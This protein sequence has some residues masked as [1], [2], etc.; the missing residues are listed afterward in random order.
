MIAIKT[1]KW[2]KIAKRR[3]PHAEW[4]TGEGPYALLAH[5]R[6]LTV[7]LWDDLDRAK[8]TKEFIDETGCG[9]FCAGYHEIVKLKS[10]RE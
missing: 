10:R 4:I 2:N 1:G 8:A 7:S 5:C 9:G 3:W 6:V